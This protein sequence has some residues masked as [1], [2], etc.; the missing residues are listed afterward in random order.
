M[1]KTSNLKTNLLWKSWFVCSAVALGSLSAASAWGSDWTR[2]LGPD[3]G[4]KEE[5]G[6]RGPGWRSR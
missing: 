5:Y 4:G 3:G 2:F 6:Y 1:N